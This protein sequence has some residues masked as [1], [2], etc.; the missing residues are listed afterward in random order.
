[1]FE[2]FKC[3]RGR[4]WI[5]F[6]CTFKLEP[7]RAIHT[8]QQLK[9]VSFLIDK[10][11]FVRQ[12]QRYP[13]WKALWDC[14]EATEFVPIDIDSATV[15]N[16]GTYSNEDHLKG[17]DLHESHDKRKPE[18]SINAVTIHHLGIKGNDRRLIFARRNSSDS[19]NT[20]SRSRGIEYLMRA[21]ASRNKFS[22]KFSEALNGAI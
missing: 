7:I 8:S 12:L 13:R 4:A 3:L 14:L 17:K 19:S 16:N 22:G 2:R 20:S 9:L 18:Y 21:Y 10:G 6:T 15:A 5:E 1:M 11:V